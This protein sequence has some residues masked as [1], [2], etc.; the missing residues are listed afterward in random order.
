[1]GCGKGGESIRTRKRSW[2]LVG[3]K[4][5]K[6]GTRDVPQVTLYTDY[7]VQYPVFR[8]VPA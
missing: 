1:M 4:A 8:G 6:Q 5:G 3:R 7:C 2:R